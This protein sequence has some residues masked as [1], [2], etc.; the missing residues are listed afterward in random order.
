MP[1]VHISA[2]RLAARALGAG[3]LVAG[4]TTE[5]EL[6]AAQRLV[7]LLGNR[8]ALA[9]RIPIPSS[10]GMRVSNDGLLMVGKDLF[11]PGLLVVTL[12]QAIGFQ[13][14][15]R[16]FEQETDGEW[17]VWAV[18]PREKV[19][20]AR[21]VFATAL[22]F[23]WAQREVDVNL[24]KS[25][26]RVGMMLGVVVGLIGHFSQEA[27]R[28]EPKDAMVLWAEPPEKVV[29]EPPPAE[30]GV[31]IPRAEPEGQN[32]LKGLS[33]VQMFFQDW[34]EAGQMMGQVLGCLRSRTPPKKRWFD[35]PR[36][37]V[38]FQARDRFREGM[39]S[40]PITVTNMRGRWMPFR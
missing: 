27:R 11:V 31:G 16:P 20:E 23:V 35:D 13:C 28:G 14:E 39:A 25:D 12:L 5:A 9:E 17:Y 30:D 29:V 7:T 10:P 33:I 3:R 38:P 22:F 18:G 4:A 21:L 6:D 34:I 8:G 36:M 37:G 26:H 15:G 1:L 2:R 24:R 32:A 19:L 40:A